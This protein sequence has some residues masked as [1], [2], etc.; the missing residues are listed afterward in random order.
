MWLSNILPLWTIWLGS[1]FL[2]IGGSISVA[3]AMLYTM[4][5]DVVPV[6][7]RSVTSENYFWP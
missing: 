2:F 7:E 6:A 5:A 4:V 1:L 3:V